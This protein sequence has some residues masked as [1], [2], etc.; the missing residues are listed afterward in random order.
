VNTGTAAEPANFDRSSVQMSEAAANFVWPEAVPTACASLSKEEWRK[1]YLAAQEQL[2]FICQMLHLPP[3]NIG[4]LA[5]EAYDHAVERADRLLDQADAFWHPRIGDP[6]EA[7]ETFLARYGEWA[8]APLWVVGIAQERGVDGHNVTVSEQW[9]IR[10]DGDRFTDGFYINRSSGL[11]DD[12][13]PRLP[14]ADQI[15]EAA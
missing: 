13:R 12:L 6:V 7:S 5:V 14:T 15:G 8:R 9:P 4:M 2:D 1:M 10:D 3:G 11:P